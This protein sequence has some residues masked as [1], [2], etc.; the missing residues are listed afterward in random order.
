MLSLFTIVLDFEHPEIIGDVEV[1][2]ICGH[3]GVTL[4]VQIT[5]KRSI[6]PS[7]MNANL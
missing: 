5:V 4:G 2:R 6:K 3:D 7:E 1:V